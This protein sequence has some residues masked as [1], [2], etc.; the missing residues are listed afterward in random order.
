MVDWNHLEGLLSPRFLS[1][2][3]VFLTS[4]HVRLKLLGQE[5]HFENQAI[6]PVVLIQ[7][8]TKAALEMESE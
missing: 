3:F 2:R 1:Q 4:S 8:K 7:K 6:I 5:P